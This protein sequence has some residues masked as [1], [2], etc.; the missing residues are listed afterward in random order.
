MREY[1]KKKIGGR[2]IKFVALY[3]LAT[4]TALLTGAAV[5]MSL[6]SFRAGF[7]NGGEHGF[8]EALYAQVNGLAQRNR[9]TP[10]G[11][12]RSQG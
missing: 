1:L 8:S 3:I 10:Q 4:P 2:E 12:L 11:Q 9:P 5:A 6:P 7:N